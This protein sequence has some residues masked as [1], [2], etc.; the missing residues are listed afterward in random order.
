M[1]ESSPKPKKK[2]KFWINLIKTILTRVLLAIIVNQ[3]RHLD[4]EDLFSRI[5][6]SIFFL[7]SLF[8]IMNNL[9][10]ALRWKSLARKFN[11]NLNLL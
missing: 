8:Y 2:K 9:F 5:H 11:V 6:W 3:L 10:G 1:T 7:A 4:L